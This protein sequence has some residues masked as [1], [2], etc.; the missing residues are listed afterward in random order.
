MRDHF[1]GSEYLQSETIARKRKNIGKTGKTSE[2]FRSFNVVPFPR[3]RESNR[4]RRSQISA[5]VTSERRPLAAPTI[6]GRW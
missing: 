5:F 3:Q 2:A 4:P 1:R 6:S